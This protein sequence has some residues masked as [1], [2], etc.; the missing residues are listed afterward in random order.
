MKE[1]LRAIEL[2]LGVGWVGQPGMRGR[3][4]EALIRHAA[5]AIVKDIG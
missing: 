3:I 2:M 5:T 4:G 1:F